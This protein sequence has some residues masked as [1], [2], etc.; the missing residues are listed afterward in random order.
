VLMPDQLVR[1]GRAGEVPGWIAKFNANASTDWVWR[2]PLSSLPSTVTEFQLTPFYAD[3]LA[4]PS[5]DASWANVDTETR[6][7]NVR[8][9]ALISGDWYDP[10]QVGTVRNY[11]GMRSSA[12]TPEARAGTKLVMGAY[13]HSGDSGTPTFGNDTF[14]PTLQYHLRFFDHYLKGVDNGIDRA[15]PVNLYVLVPPDTGNQGHGSW[16]AAAEW[17][18]P[19]THRK[20]LYLHSGGRANTRLGDG[21]LVE[22]E[23]DLR[24]GDDDDDRPAPEHADRLVYD[25]RDPAPTTGGNM[26]CNGTLVPAGAREQSNV[27]LRRDVLVYTS[28][29]LEADMTVIGDVVVKLWARS[30]ARDTDFTAKLVDVHRDGATHNVLDRIV[31]ARYRRGS[32]L[33]PA[34]IHPGRTYDYRIELGNTA[35]VFRAGHRVRLEVSSSNF[36]H[37]ARNLN[38][39]LS[40]EDTSSI[41]VARQTVLHDRKH[42]SRLELPI[43]PVAVP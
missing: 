7:D 28:A 18:V 15:A 40:N 5:Y 41:E 25:P 34:L 1:A 13:G 17:P 20:N 38:T 2:L 29:P 8:V 3:W 6:Y 32:K 35:T 19:G 37:F 43:A 36:P 23:R 42:P 24:D 9:P 39:G 21:V 27:E 10:F 14:D 26:C 31:R 16:I 12:A 11:L 30:S 33:P 22:S 4:H